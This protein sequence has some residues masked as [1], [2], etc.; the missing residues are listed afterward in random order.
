[1]TEASSN[2]RSAFLARPAGFLALAL[3]VFFA[4]DRLAGLGLGR[5]AETS[6]HR[7]ARV[8]QADA[9][10]SLVVLGHSRGVQLLSPEAARAATGLPVYNLAANGMSTA[11]AEALLMDHVDNGG[12]P[13]G[14]VVEVT[15]LCSDNSLVRDLKLFARRSGRIAGILEEEEPVL[16]AAS[17]WVHAFRYNGDLMPRILF[18]RSRDDQGLTNFFV[19]TPEFLGDSPIQES[20]WRIQDGNPEALARLVAWARERKIPV[21]LV[22]GPFW[23]AAEAGA[24]VSERVVEA[25]GAV[26]DE[27]VWDYSEALAEH[28]FFADHVHLNADGTMALHR[29]LL[30]SGFYAPWQRPNEQE[31]KQ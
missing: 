8:Y 29:A 6:R 1:M 12:M 11:I 16:A 30:E 18:H 4:I 21:R 10:P 5:V 13:A 2:A 20:D 23:P 31:D 17:D 25:V 24:T 28:R 9:V 19:A 26:T 15:T 27:R 3:L 7:F 14:L 22:V